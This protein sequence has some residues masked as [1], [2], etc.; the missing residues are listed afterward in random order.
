M[1]NV[2]FLDIYP[3]DWYRYFFGITVTV[4]HIELT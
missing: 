3:C 1:M 4:G 2:N